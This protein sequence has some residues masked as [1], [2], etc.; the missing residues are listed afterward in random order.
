LSYPT[1]VGHIHL[2]KHSSKVSIL[3]SHW[4]YMSYS[5]IPHL[6]KG[7]YLALSFHVEASFHFIF[8]NKGVIDIFI[9]EL[10]PYQC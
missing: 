5:F 10:T 4:L 7:F 1:L 9:C 2:N 3:G 6:N 8:T